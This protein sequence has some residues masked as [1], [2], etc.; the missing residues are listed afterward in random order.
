MEHRKFGVGQPVRR[1][2]D[3]RF[4]TG[5]GRYTDDQRPEGCTYA[6]VVR[7]PHAH[8]RFRF[9]DL[10]AARA[11]PGVLLILTHADVAHLGG[12]PCLGTVVNADGSDMAT[13][14][15]PVLCEDTVRHVGDAVAFVVA[16][17]EEQAR[18]AAEGLEIDWEPLPAQV[19]ITED[20]ADGPPVWPGRL[21]N[22]AFDTEVGDA[23]KT[24][25]AFAKAARTVRLTLDADA[26]QPGQPRVAGQSGPPRPQG[27]ARP[28]PGRHA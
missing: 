4:V 10:G 20:G 23:A 14:P 15:Y 19:G 8:A 1:V 6:V 16:E 25:T 28:G 21:G 24:D 7:S 11:R 12:I 9:G 2:E 3:I 17:T 5:G 27:E 13:P 18:A 22:L 26:R